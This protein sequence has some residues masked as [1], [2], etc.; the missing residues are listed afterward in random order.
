MVNRHEAV[1]SFALNV[2]QQLLQFS[3]YSSIKFNINALI[4][5]RGSGKTTFG[6]CWLNSLVELTN[7]TTERS[8]LH[9]YL[10]NKCNESKILDLLVYLYLS[11]RFIAMELPMEG[12]ENSKEYLLHYVAKYENISEDSDLFDVPDLYDCMKKLLSLI[13]PTTVISDWCSFSNDNETLKFWRSIQ[14][15][16]ITQKFG[17]F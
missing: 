15:K 13:A 9:H 10:H 5:T 7:N 14:M 11:N 1:V 12:F 16:E 17:H 2:C 6:T 4:G 3:T 8:K